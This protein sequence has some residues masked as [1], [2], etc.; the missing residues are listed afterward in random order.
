M[1]NIWSQNVEYFWFCVYY[2]LS[3]NCK[4]L[5]ISLLINGRHLIVMAKIANVTGPVKRDQVGTKN[6]TSQNGTYIEFCVQYLL[7]VSCRML[8][9]KLI[10]N[11]TNFTYIALA[12]H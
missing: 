7:S 5:L 3:V 6:T 12:D 4:T 10:M 11:G 2:L 1:P 9:M 8:P